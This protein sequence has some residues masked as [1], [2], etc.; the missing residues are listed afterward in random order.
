M[1]RLT[2]RLFL[3]LRYGQETM[4]FFPSLIGQIQQNFEKSASFWPMRYKEQIDGF[5]F[6]TD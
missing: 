4:C 2:E 1:V 5:I 6:K 3:M